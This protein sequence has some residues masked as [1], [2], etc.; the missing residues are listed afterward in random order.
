MI[1][2]F[3]CKLRTIKYVRQTQLYTRDVHTFSHNIHNVIPL[4][5]TNYKLMKQECSPIIIVRQLRQIYLQNLLDI[6]H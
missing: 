2:I 3:G 4:T 6:F 5:T 1:A